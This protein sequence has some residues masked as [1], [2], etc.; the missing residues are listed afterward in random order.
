MFL[1]LPLSLSWPYEVCVC[2]Y[3]SVLVLEVLPYSKAEKIPPWFLPLAFF[4]S[5]FKIW[6]FNPS[7]FCSVFCVTSTQLYFSPRC[8]SVPPLPPATYI[9]SFRLW[10]LEPPA[11]RFDFPHPEESISGLSLLFCWFICF[12]CEHHSY[13]YYCTSGIS[14]NPS[15]AI[16]FSLPFWDWA[17]KGHFLLPD[18]F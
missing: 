17:H 7:G 1:H 6:G 14:L 15:E 10:F 9:P 3:F 18:E 4:S 5:I 16:C 12:V 2:M 11:S 8:P 13:F